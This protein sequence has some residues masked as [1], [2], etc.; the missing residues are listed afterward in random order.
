MDICGKTVNMSHQPQPPPQQQQQQQ[1]P[2][3]LMV[4]VLLSIF[5]H[6]IL[7]LVFHNLKKANI[8]TNP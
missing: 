6:I 5:T 4:H 3:S 1:Q 7:S 2:P 8:L